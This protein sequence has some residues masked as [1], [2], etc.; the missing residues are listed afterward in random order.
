MI[1]VS[2]DIGLISHLNTRT[3]FFDVLLLI[4]LPI[5]Q[6]LVNAVSRDCPLPTYLGLLDVKNADP[7]INP[8]A[9]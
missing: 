4:F 7:M 6:L 2:K 5:P 9:F 8:L 1:R 3:V